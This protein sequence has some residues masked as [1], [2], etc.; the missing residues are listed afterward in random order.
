MTTQETSTHPRAGAAVTGTVRIATDIAMIAL[1]DPALLKEHVKEPRRWWEADPFGTPERQDGRLALWPLGG[2]GG[3]YRVRLGPALEEAERPY[4]RGAS[5]PAPLVVS[6]EG[7]VFLG[8]AERLPGDGYG[9]RYSAIPDKGGLI[10][11]PPGT[12]GITAHALDWRPE[13]RF[14]DEENEPTPDAPPDFVLV[15][16]QVDALPPAPPA[17]VKPLLEL[18]PQKKARGGERIVTP[19]VRPRAPIVLEDEKPQ[20]RRAASGSSAPRREPAA[21]ARPEPLRVAPGKPGE[22]R[23]GARV[24]HATYGLGSVVF[25]REGFP[26]ARVAFDAS[27]EEV[28]VDKSE[29]TVLS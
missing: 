20:R 12:Y 4:D 23:E 21:R 22:L 9:D 27:G 28:K 16:E 13:A 25:F 29:L 3:L 7:Q 24:R 18:L 2:R 1:F 5:P 26:K 17:P 10:D 11:L 19:A 6:P 15:Y 8:P 14:W